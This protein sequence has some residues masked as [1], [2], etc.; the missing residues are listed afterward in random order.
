MESR[1]NFFFQTPSFQNFILH[2]LR[3]SDEGSEIWH[4]Q[5]KLQNFIL[6]PNYIEA[7][8]L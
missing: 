3:M 1:K 7:N 5:F 6:S 2:F 8:F 4:T